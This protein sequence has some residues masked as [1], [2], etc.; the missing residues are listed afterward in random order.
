MVLALPALLSMGVSELNHM[1][2]NML[3]SGLP[4]G[5]LTSLTSSYRLVTFLQGVLISCR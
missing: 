3:A 4:E 5:T 2:D 1:I